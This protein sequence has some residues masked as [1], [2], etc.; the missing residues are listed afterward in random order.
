MSGFLLRAMSVLALAV[1]LVSGTSTLEAGESGVLSKQLAKLTKAESLTIEGR[2]YFTYWMEIQDEKKQGDGEEEPLRN[3]FE[4]NRFYFGLK[5]QILPWLS[6]RFTSDVGPEKKKV[7]TSKAEDGHVHEVDGEQSYQFFIKYAYLDATLARGLVLRAG[8]VDNP[9]NDF[10]DGYW[11]YRFVMKNV[12][13][14]EKVWDSADL[15]VQLRYEL[16]SA[17]GQ[18]ALGAFNGAGYKTA[19]DNDAVKNLWLFFNLTPFGTLGEFGKRFNLAGYVSKGI[20][21]GPDEPTHLTYSGTLGYTCTNLTVAYQLLGNGIENAAMDDRTW[22][23][24]H[25]AYLRVGLPAKLG[26]LG[27]LAI[28]DADTD[29]DANLKKYQVLAGLGWNPHSLFQVAASG[30]VTWYD[31]AEGTPET[32]ANIRFLLSSEFRF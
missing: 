31:D 1:C 27:R 28:W 14:E 26:V 3:S 2:A 6:F 7:E 17:W 12:G 29:N 18:V 24:G 25:G 4:L 13:D 30:L 23:M 20:S 10:I 19:T 32:E 21:L 8:V 9:Y 22:G 15:G 5:G 11:G 16:P